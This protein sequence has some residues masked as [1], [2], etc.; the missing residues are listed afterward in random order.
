MAQELPDDGKAFALDVND[1]Y[2]KVGKPFMEKAG[3]LSKV[4]LR[5]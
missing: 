1:E 4:F 2:V 5:Y 3:V